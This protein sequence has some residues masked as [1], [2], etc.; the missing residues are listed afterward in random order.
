M[1][2][3]QGVSYSKKQV[4]QAPMLVFFGVRELSGEKGGWVI[5]IREPRKIKIFSHCILPPV[6][7][8]T[9]EP[10]PVPEVSLSLFIC[11]VFQTG[12][13]I[14]FCG[15]GPFLEKS[16]FLAGPRIAPMHKGHVPQMRYHFAN[17]WYWARLD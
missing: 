2:T 3:P 11:C 8:E 16:S 7:P 1:Q 12:L 13:S 10:F 17:V 5:I 4:R 6:F 15:K 9:R 14:G